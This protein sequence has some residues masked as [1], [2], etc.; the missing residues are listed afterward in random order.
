MGGSLSLLPPGY[1]LNGAYDEAFEPDGSPRPGYEQLLQALN[2]A[3]LDSVSTAVHAEMVG[4]GVTF[5]DRHAPFPADPVPRVLAG[6]DWKVLSRGLAQRARALQAF[7]ADAYGDR[8]MVAA[9]LIPRE[10]I[11]TADHFEPWMLDVPMPAWAYS[12]LAGPDIVRCSDGV[13][14]VLEDNMRTPSG[15]AYVWAVRAAT[16]AQLPMDPPA[17][18]LEIGQAAERVR[19][20]LMAAA[21]GG[22]GQAVLLSD[23]PDNTAWYEHSELAKR[24]A[25][26]LVLPGDLHVRGGRLRAVVEGGVRTVEVVYRRTD[27]DRLRD[28]ATGKPTWLAELLLEPCRAGRL[29]CVNGLGSG[30]ADDKL[31]HA[32]VE[33][34]VRFY[35][36]EEPLIESVPTYDLTDP[37]CRAEALAR[38]D[39]LVV[40]PRSGFGGHGLVVCPHARAEDVRAV[41]RRIEEH[42]SS[43]VAQET[44]TMSRHPTV[45]RCELV[46]RHVDLRSFVIS[47]GD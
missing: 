21:P 23:G 2:A 4:R 27:Q 37:G 19:A 40:K 33:E 10:I 35:L 47:A 8:R 39:E 29:A 12:P 28:P 15:L 43:W 1:E 7:T 3:S 26:P 32:Y 24:L 17:D 11:E 22:E 25:I 31:V 18:R 30:V 34:M 42:P 14:R 5:G 45:E 38:L 13:L 20:A 6:E 44:V 46:P 16:D 41:A 36:G 9:G